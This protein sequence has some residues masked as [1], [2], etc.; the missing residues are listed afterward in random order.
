MA[1]MWTVS[2][3]HILL[4]TVKL[5][6][7]VEN[8]LY[9]ARYKSVKHDLEQFPIYIHLFCYTFY[10][11]EREKSFERNTKVNRNR[12]STTIRKIEGVLNG[13]NGLLYL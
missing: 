13:P 4:A 7:T 5:D 9:V 11:V 3:R 8:Q 2:I 6:S 1:R 10:S 12:G